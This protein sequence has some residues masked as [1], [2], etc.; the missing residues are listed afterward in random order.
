MNIQIGLRKAARMLR[1]VM[2]GGKIR[3][4]KRDYWGENNAVR[5][6]K[7][8]RGGRLEIV[9]Q[10]SNNM[11]IIEDECKLKLRNTI[12]IQGDNNIV[13]LHRNVTFDQNVLLVAC[14]GT[15]IVFGEDCI[16]ANGVTVRTS[17]QHGIYGSNG[18]RI[19]LPKDVNIGDH[20]WLGAH[21]VVMK[22]ATIGEDSVIGMNSMVTKNIPPHCVAV[23][24]PARVIK[25]DITWSERIR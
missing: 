8:I 16:V 17:D 19:N 9:F 20:V 14:E 11:V 12:F 5:R 6:G 3:L 24:T 25:E 7:N 2:G 1:N 15:K 18:A 23:G 10:G 22:G 21:V 13:H 4:I